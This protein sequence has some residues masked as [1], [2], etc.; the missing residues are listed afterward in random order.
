MTM[1]LAINLHVPTKPEAIFLNGPSRSMIPGQ[2]HCIQLLHIG[3]F[4]Q[5]GD[6]SFYGRGRVAFIPVVLGD[7]KGNFPVGFG[8]FLL[9]PCIAEADEGTRLFFN[10]SKL[11][12]PVTDGGEGGEECLVIGDF[13]I[14]QPVQALFSCGTP[15]GQKFI[16]LRL[17]RQVVDGFCV[18]WLKFS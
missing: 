14:R 18:R 3:L 9:D 4:N 13:V 6:E 10:D 16:D 5:E 1:H 17:G 11:E 12:P 15:V 2:D 8:E 7:G